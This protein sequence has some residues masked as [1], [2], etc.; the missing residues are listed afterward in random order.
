MARALEVT[1]TPLD[2]G[3][4]RVGTES[5]ISLELR[6][7]GDIVV[8]LPTFSLQESVAASGFELPSALPSR[9]QPG[10]S[11]T[12]RVTCRPRR[13]GEHTGTIV[14][15]TVVRPRPRR[16]LHG[17][18][19]I[20]ATAT[21]VA[22]SVFLAA[23]TFP[24]LT[25]RLPRPPIL[26]DLPPRPGL[27]LRDLTELQLID[28]GPV[29]PRHSLER[30]FRIRSVGDLPV[31]VAEVSA[32]PTDL[33]GVPDP[34]TFPRQLA[35]GQEMTVAVNVAA[36]STDG[37]LLHGVVTVVTDDPQ[38][39]E[40]I[41]DVRAEVVGPRL[42]ADEGID[43]GAGASPLAA[44][45]TFTSA[46]TLPVVVTNISLRDDP[47]FA[48]AGPPVLPLTIDPGGT[49]TLTVVCAGPVSQPRG[50]LLVEWRGGANYIH[51]SADI[52]S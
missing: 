39:P 35:P 9:L 29:A 22:P 17:R 41:L 27:D 50:Q 30:A 52:T 23:P 46:G 4:V 11:A 21:G 12:V 45:L 51:L 48:L 33:F 13:R 16:E 10:E 3:P 42:V 6:N 32:A 25:G 8:E 40:L 38:R 14:I 36:P 19:E 1:P 26:T 49:M 20:P 15:E 2:F 34:G 24:P 18:V 7:A 47:P 43:F 44:S 5:D 37:R 31:R 28:F